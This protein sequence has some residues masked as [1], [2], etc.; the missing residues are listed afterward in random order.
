MHACEMITEGALAV[1]RGQPDQSRRRLRPYRG[2]RLFALAAWRDTPFYG[3][4][5]SWWRPHQGPGDVVSDE[6]WDELAKHYDEKR[7]AALILYIAT[8]AF[9]NTVDA[10]IKEPAGTTWK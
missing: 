7:R 6:L 8:G 4:S 3:R 9:F 10:T 2:D 5:R 1:L